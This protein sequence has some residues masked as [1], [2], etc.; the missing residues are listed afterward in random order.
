MP[1]YPMLAAGM[2]IAGD[3]S[4]ESMRFMGTCAAY[5]RRDTYLTAAHCTELNTGETLLVLM[6]AETGTRIVR[7]VERHPSTDVAVIVT[8]PA[9]DEPLTAHTYKAIDESLID[10]GDF[11][12]C[13]WSGPWRRGCLIFASW[14]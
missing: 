4:K 12:G 3:A 11:I 2:L 1:F 9:R 13:N 14:C 10:G 5:T 6:Q 8:E 7:H